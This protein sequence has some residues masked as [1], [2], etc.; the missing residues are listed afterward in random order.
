MTNVTADGYCQDLST[1]NTNINTGTTTALLEEYEPRLRGRLRNYLCARRLAETA[2][3]AMLNLAKRLA[4]SSDARPSGPEVAVM[5][6][7]ERQQTRVASLESA[8]IEAGLESEELDELFYMVEEVA[9]GG[10]EES[11]ATEEAAESLVSPASFAENQK[12]EKEAGGVEASTPRRAEHIGAPS[13]TGDDDL[14]RSSE[15]QSAVT[16][17]LKEKPER[18]VRIDP[19]TGKQKKRRGTPQRAAA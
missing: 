14:T 15:E 4:A 19:K 6:C 16:P 1:N 9:N 12:E 5:R 10:G 7:Y 8:L 2:E 11:L 13:R 3:L 18:R 17:F